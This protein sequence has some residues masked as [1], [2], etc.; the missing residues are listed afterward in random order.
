MG[1]TECRMLRIIRDFAPKGLKDSARGF[2]PG[3]A[4]LMRRALKGHKMEF[5]R[6]DRIIVPVEIQS[7]ATFRAHVFAAV[8]PGLKPWA[9]SYYPFGVTL[10]ETTA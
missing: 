1:G 3:L 4:M 6:G 7:S 10:C 9:E 8:A 2:N 5:L